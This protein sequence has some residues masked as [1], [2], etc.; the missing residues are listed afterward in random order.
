MVDVLPIDTPTLGDRSYLAH[1]GD[2]AVVIDPQRDVDRVSDLA[3]QLG[4]RVTH[5]AETHIHNDYVTGGLALAEAAGASYLV[6]G[7][8][9]VRFSRTAVQDGDQV[10]VSDAMTLRV[11]ATPGHT[12]SHLAYVLESAGTVLGVFTGGSLLYGSTGRPD[13][14]GPGQHAG[15]GPR[16]VPVRAPAG[17]RA[18]R[19]GGDLSHA[20]VRQ[21]LRRHRGPGLSSTIGQ[22]KQVNPALTREERSYVAALLAGL[23]VWPAY[24]AHMAPANAAGPAAP[25]LSAPH[26]ADPAELRRRIEAGEW[27]VDLRDRVAFAAGFLPGRWRS[28]S[29]AASPPI[30]AGRCPGAPR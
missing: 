23:D 10:P 7:A 17:H 6:N 28:R 27:V 19:H 22:E 9:P 4:V 2:V 1:D 5:V 14:L 8:D 20:R 18:A 21:L 26:R 12:F 29:M 30:W 13:L 16:P 11:L 24:Y 15:A 25:D 3:A